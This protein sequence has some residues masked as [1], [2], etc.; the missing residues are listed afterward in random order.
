MEKNKHM[1]QVEAAYP[2]EYPDH[3]VPFIQGHFILN[4]DQSLDSDTRK[5][6]ITWKGLV[7]GTNVEIVQ[8]LPEGSY[9]GC[10]DWTGFPEKLE[11]VKG[12]IIVAIDHA[13][14]ASE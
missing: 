13:I 7:G 6:P 12:Y 14:N 2:E 4:A 1:T 5:L 11:R 10:F 9:E 8:V 3:P